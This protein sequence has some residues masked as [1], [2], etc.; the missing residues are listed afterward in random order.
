MRR[1]LPGSWGRYHRRVPDPVDGVETVADADRVQPVPLVLCANA[2]VDL[3]V[4]VQVAVRVA[5]TGGVMAHRHRLD[6]LHRNL[7][8]GSARTDPGRRVLRK[9]THNLLGRAL[10]SR[11]IRGGNVRVNSRGERPGFRSIDRDLDEPHCVFTLPQMPLRLRRRRVEAGD[12]RLVDVSRQRSPMPYAQ[13]GGRREMLGQT[14]PLD[15]VVVVR[16][17]PV[18]LQIVARSG[19]RIPVDRHSAVHFQHLPITANKY[20]INAQEP[21]QNGAT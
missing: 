7:H 21:P 5:G 1:G 18:G 4:Q 15:Q 9:P 12:P 8:L 6:L 17:G 20:P 10:L 11:V 19:R 14:S 3:Q 2:G 16:P 13:S